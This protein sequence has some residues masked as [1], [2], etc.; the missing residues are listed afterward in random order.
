MAEPCDVIEL[1]TRDHAA[2]NQLA[3]QLDASESPAEIRELFL[4]V[5][6]RLAAHEAAEQEVLF[7]A[8]HQAVPVAD[9]EASTRSSEHEEINELLGEM[10]ALR[11]DGLA[12]AKRASALLLDIQGH[13][14]A[15]EDT[16]FP[17]L[18]ATLPR[19]ALL[20]LAVRVETVMEHAPAWPAERADVG[21]S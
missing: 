10:R 8:V 7:P 15:E 20:A 9:A 5:V 16:L 1:L 21:L 13:F 11:P 4:R 19:S 3:E 2:I 18:A 14:Q 17:R 12:F 6:E